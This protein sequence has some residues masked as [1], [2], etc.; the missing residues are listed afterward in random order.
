MPE[1]HDV[2]TF[3]TPHGQRSTRMFPARWKALT[4]DGRGGVFHQR[5]TSPFVTRRSGSEPAAGRCA[6]LTAKA[7]SVQEAGP[8]GTPSGHAQRD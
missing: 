4:R 8:A 1:A 5:M 7:G 2:Q 3:G 6:Q